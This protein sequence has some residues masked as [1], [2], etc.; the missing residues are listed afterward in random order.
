MYSDI[1][2]LDA[3]GAR[4]LTDHAGI[5]WANPVWSPD[6]TQIAYITDEHQLAVI[7]RDGSGGA[8]LTPKSSDGSLAAVYPEWLPDGN[9]SVI[10]AGKIAVLRTD[11]SGVRVLTPEDSRDGSF[12]WS[13]DGTQIVLGGSEL[14]PPEVFVFDPESGESRTLLTPPRPFYAFDWS[15]DGTMI[16]AGNWTHAQ[17]DIDDSLHDLFVFDANGEGLQ[18]LVQ[19][20][21]ES[22]PA[23]S[24]D[25]KMIVYEK[26][27]QD[28]DGSS[29][30]LWVMN[31]DGTGAQQLLSFGHQPDWT[32]R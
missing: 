20:G 1:Y 13:P 7:N 3:Q 9:I 23:W 30:G 22:N 6:G 32:A 19:P 15:A 10:T 24:P 14:L 17:A 27:I 11:G 25:G 16:V 28:S 21:R 18:A 29:D 2:L 5:N 31:A 12:A 26:S 8:Y 4:V